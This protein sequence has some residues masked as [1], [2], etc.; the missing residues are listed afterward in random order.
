LNGKDL[1]LFENYSQFDA[2]LATSQKGSLFVRHTTGLTR[3]L[4]GLDALI[5]NLA[6][7]GITAPIYIMYFSSLLYPGVNLPLTVLV[8]IPPS[9]VMAAI[10]YLLTMSMPRTGGDFVWVSRI[11]HPSLG[12]ITN[13]FITFGLV[14]FTAIVIGTIPVYGIGPMFTG[15]GQILSNE[16]WVNQART[17]STAPAG[18]ELSLAILVV[19]I[20]PVFLG[21]RILFRILGVVLTVAAISAVVMTLAFFSTPNSVFIH[22]FN[23]LSGMNYQSI[24]TRAAMP[25]GFSFQYTL[26]GSVYTILNFVGYSNS[27]YYTGEVRQVQRSQVIAMFGA[28]LIFATLLAIQYTSVYYSLGSDFYGAL[29]ALAGSSNSAYTL[30]VAPVLTILVTYASPNAFVISFVALG[31]ILTQIAAFI[32]VVFIVQRNFFSWSFD[33]LIPSAFTTLDTR[34][35]PYLST[36]TIFLFSILFTVLYWYTDLFSY[37]LYSSLLISIA[38][39][40]TSLT[41]IVFPYRCKD[42]F[43]ASPEIVRKRVGNVPII[44]ILGIAGLI[45]E[46]FISYATVLPS[47]TPPP[48]GPLIVQLLS[49]SLVPIVAVAGVLIYASAYLYRRSQGLDLT[50]LF[51]Q[52]P[53]E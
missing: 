5:A 4:S 32:I 43:E 12:L 35:T 22:N 18:F 46:V 44:T 19:T 29:A 34:G 39:A 26:Y 7:M 23:N 20:I 25:T 37:F 8:A 14:S 49:Y 21:T 33:R 42:M 52:V 27:A 2:G 17:V 16:N 13:L 11:I 40:I 24:I 53:P 51:K 36:I 38:F 47:V 48:A 28:I 45:M 41:A 1:K 6:S 15:L 3:N 30:P 10:Y 31:F 9:L 50:L